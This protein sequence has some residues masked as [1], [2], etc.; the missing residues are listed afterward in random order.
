MEE[1]RE[2]RRSQFGGKKGGK[3]KQEGG[4]VPLLCSEPMSDYAKHCPECRRMHVGMSCP[5]DS[6]RGAVQSPVS[7][8]SSASRRAAGDILLIKDIQS[9]GRYFWQPKCRYNSSK[10]CHLQLAAPRAQQDFSDAGC[11]PA[12]PSICPHVSPHQPESHK[13]LP[14]PHRHRTP[15]FPHRTPLPRESFIPIPR[16]RLSPPHSRC[17]NLR[18]CS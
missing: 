18:V 6:P 7:R 12:T 11:P 17:V 13:G 9:A 2:G 15:L 5:W 3:P 16:T 14:S 10:I 8:A 1:E 4:S